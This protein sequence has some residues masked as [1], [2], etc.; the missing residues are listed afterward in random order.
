MDLNQIFSGDALHKDDL[1]NRDWTLTIKTV[2]QK[3]FDDGA[4]IILTFVEAQKALVCNKTNAETIG[5]MYGTRNV[6]QIWPGKRIT[7]YNEPSVM[8]GGK[9]TGGIRVRE[10]HAAMTAQ[11]QAGI[12]QHMAAQAPLP[13]AQQAPPSFDGP[14]SNVQAPSLSEISRNLDAELDDEIPF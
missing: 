13:P 11:S 8:F 12:Q 4:K 5:M 6:D 7:I 10:D 3:D 2:G 9:R 14:P 1:G